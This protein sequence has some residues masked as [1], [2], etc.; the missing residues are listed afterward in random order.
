MIQI[1]NKINKLQKRISKPQEFKNFKN[2]LHFCLADFNNKLIN[3]KTNNLFGALFLTEKKWILFSD[4]HRNGFAT[5]IFS[6][7]F[8]LEYSR[9]SRVYSEEL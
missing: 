9:K 3:I 2:K 4:I 5:L 8:T 7:K 1:I 6:R